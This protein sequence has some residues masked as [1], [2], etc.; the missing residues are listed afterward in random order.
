[1]VKK[2]LLRY[3]IPLLGLG[4]FNSN[5]S[6]HTLSEA[7]AHAITT[8]PDL[9]IVANNREAVDHELRE[10]YA[11]YLPTLDIAAG[12]GRE[13]SDNATTRG[14]DGDEGSL[15]LTRS[16]F[17]ANARQMLFDGFAVQND[18]EGNMA[19]VRAAAWRVNGEAQD[20]ALRVAEAFLDVNLRKKLTRLAKI[21][22][23]AHQAIFG[24]IQKLSEG[25]IGR[26][27]DLDQAEG[28]LALARTNLLAEQA[29]LRDAETNYLRIVGLPAIALTQ[30]D[31]P[32]DGFP[33][34]QRSAIALGVNNHPVLRASVSDVQVAKSAHKAA[35]APFY[36]RFDIEL[37][38]TQNH[39]LDGTRGN[40]DDH[41]AMLRMRWNLFAG[42]AD[43]ARIRSTAWNVQE[44]QEVRNRAHRQVEESVRLAWNTYVTSGAQKRYFRQ[45][46]NAAERTRDAYQKQFN[47][48]QRTLL[49]LL[50][51]EN[52][53]FGAR[54]SY[55]Q[56]KH[57]ELL[58]A[59]RVLN[60][61][62]DFLNYLG[63]PLPEAASF[64][65]PS[66][67]GLI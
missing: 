41:S 37:G 57:S 36:P 2:K 27:A 43:L 54:S 38:L 61:T 14:A 48:G 60:A 35:K 17:S 19:R 40:N 53:L 31:L 16:E 52:E 29:N 10:A 21:N 47:I 39:N 58:G 49:D 24:K 15:T 44:A 30:P 56:S 9:L 6:A 65:A 3:L 26:K 4:A 59:A 11:G 51:S 46:M 32:T 5:V 50:D 42:G 25:G 12:I 34:T 28:R 22:L 7:V 18:V 13:N 33:K 55:A 63:V 45:Y 8:G 23:E 62:G 20:V 67:W 1:M 66:L 64:V